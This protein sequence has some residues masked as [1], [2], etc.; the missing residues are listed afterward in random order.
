VTGLSGLGQK[1]LVTLFA[2]DAEHGALPTLYSA[3]ANLPGGSYAGP[4]GPGER[5]GYPTIVQA[6]QDTMDE[7]LAERLW[8]TSSRLTGLAQP[9]P[10]SRPGPAREPNPKRGPEPQPPFSRIFSETNFFVSWG[11]CPRAPAPPPPAVSGPP[12]PR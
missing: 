2:Q 3:T 1:I 11:P 7:Q 9:R 8:E 12:S 10:V 6:S 5:R 4:D